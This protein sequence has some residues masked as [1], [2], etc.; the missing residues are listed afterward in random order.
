MQTTEQLTGAIISGDFW[1]F[2][3]LLNAIYQVIGDENR[4]YDYQGSRRRL[5][6]TCLKMRRATQGEYHIDY[7]TNG[8][9]KQISRNQHTVYPEKNIYF[10]VEIL[11]PE[12]IFS[13]IALNDF[14]TLHKEVIDDSEWNLHVAIIRKWQAQIAECIEPFME[15]EHYL[16]F[17]TTVHAK[18]PFYFRYATQYVDMLNLEYLALPKEERS[19]QLTAF[20]LR[21]LIQDDAY[22]VLKEQLLQV[23]NVSKQELHEIPL[24]LTYPEEIVW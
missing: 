19:Q 13:A 17:L 20:S 11:M 21:L 5:L 3:E 6:N 7:V 8:I 22:A 2:D 9:H 15:E 12:L 10:S 24:S 23:T 14:I 16:V 1:D 4:Y 18:S